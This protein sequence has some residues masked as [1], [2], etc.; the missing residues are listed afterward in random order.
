MGKE[1]LVIFGT[2][3]LLG[4]VMLVFAIRYMLY[5]RWAL[6]Q[7]AV[8]IS[9]A[10]QYE[11]VLPGADSMPAFSV[12]VVQR[13]RK[14]ECVVV[15]S[16]TDNRRPERQIKTCKFEGYILNGFLTL[17]KNDKAVKE[18]GALSMFLEIKGSG[19]EMIGYINRY[20]VSDNA[21]VSDPVIWK[22]AFF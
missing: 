20:N 17:T 9:G 18:S 3:C 11:F 16:S 2:L 21:F 8:N 10:W 7:R 4:V 19:K 1:E 13:A 22:R 14:I 5:G 12:E 6:T 15:E